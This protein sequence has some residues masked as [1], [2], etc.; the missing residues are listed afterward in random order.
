MN[1]PK[2]D[3]KRWNFIN[4][5]EYEYNLQNKERLEFMRLRI[6][7]LLRNYLIILI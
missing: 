1:G 3:F 5:D 6:N 4:D 2:G 7:Q